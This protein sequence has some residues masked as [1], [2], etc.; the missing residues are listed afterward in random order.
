MVV[1]V[2]GVEYNAFEDA[3]RNGWW[4]VWWWL[5]PRCDHSKTT[6]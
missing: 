2:K 6:R 1:S 5:A 4:M 3:T